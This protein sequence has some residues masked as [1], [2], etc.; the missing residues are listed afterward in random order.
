MLKNIRNTRK[1]RLKN[2][3][4]DD[5]SVPHDSTSKSDLKKIKKYGLVSI[6]NQFS[7]SKKIVIPSI[8]VIGFIV[9]LIPFVSHVPATLLSFIVGAFTV[10]T[11][12]TVR[13]FLENLF[14]GIVLSSSK[15]L[16][17]GDTVVVDD[18]YGTVEDISL[19]Y[20]SI[21][22]WDSKRYIIP[23]INML[24]KDFVNL[25]LVEKNQWACIEFWVSYKNNLKHIK[26]ISIECAEQ[27]KFYE[28]DNDIEFWIMH[29]EKDAV[30]CWLAVW[31][32]SPSSAW[33]LKNDVRT[34]IITKFLEENIEIHSTN[35]NININKMSEISF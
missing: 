6:E 24:N 33:N 9:G 29:M 11:G 27:S 22:T 32:D 14:A 19:T 21:K 1:N 15:S 13:P 10:V 3:K 16:N 23:N 2:K 25:T 5:F 7:I 12:I 4:T 17:L 34:N 28:A 18:N 26:E 20:T 30:K 31:T 8:L 35:S